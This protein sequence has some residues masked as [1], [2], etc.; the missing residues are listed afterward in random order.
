MNNYKYYIKEILF[1]I[2]KAFNKNAFFNIVLLYIFNEN[3]CFLVQILKTK[4]QCFFIKNTWNVRFLK[5][6]LK[7]RVNCISTSN[8]DSFN[9]RNCNK[10]DL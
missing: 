8:C 5:H 3:S 9:N 2:F 4:T 6:G 7:T 10:I 1:F